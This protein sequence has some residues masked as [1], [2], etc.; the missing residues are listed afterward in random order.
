MKPKIIVLLSTYNGEKYLDEQ[1]ESVFSQK[2]VCV[3]VYARDDGS[4]DNTCKILEK[5][6]SQFPLTWYKG[7]NKGPAES[8][9]ELLYTA[10]PSE[11]YAFCDQDDVW[12]TDKL[13][14]AVRILSSMPHEKPS[15]YFSGYRTVDKDLKIISESV[16][17]RVLSYGNALVEN[18]ALGCSMVFNDAAKELACRIHATDGSMHDAWLYKI[19]YTTGNVYFD[20]KSRLSYRQHSTNVIGGNRSFF[21]KWTRRMKRFKKIWN[22]RISSHCRVLKKHCEAYIIAPD[23]MKTLSTLTDYKDSFKNRLNL[24]FSKEI[25][26]QSRLDNLIFKIVVLLGKL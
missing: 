10:P 23:K 17:F 2:N 7:K 19:C 1:L 3:N 20:E 6:A 22:G 13:E 18:I 26:R 14:S 16:N 11:F 25:V 24:L 8:F 15:L 4:S 12:D 21:I 9:M 5:W